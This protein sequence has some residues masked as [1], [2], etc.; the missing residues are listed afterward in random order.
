MTFEEVL[1]QLRITRKTLLRIIRD[2]EL[3]AYRVGAQ[4]RIPEK[5]VTD[6]LA[7]TRATAGV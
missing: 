3:T 6:Y 7:G 2:G 5:A 4:W 1:A